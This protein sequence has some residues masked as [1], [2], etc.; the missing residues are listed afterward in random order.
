MMF[1]WTVICTYTEQTP[2]SPEI[3]STE[4]TF[5]HNQAMKDASFY[6][7]LGNLTRKGC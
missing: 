5:E 2:S 7:Q 6:A 4:F 3:Q 1:V